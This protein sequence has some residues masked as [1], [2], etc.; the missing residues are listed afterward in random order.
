MERKMGNQDL[1]Y[2]LFR[3]E[4][5]LDTHGYKV[6]TK[7]RQGWMLE[8][9]KEKQSKFN[10][11]TKL[12]TFPVIYP[13]VFNFY[14]DKKHFLFNQE[15]SYFYLICCNGKTGDIFI[16]KRA[17]MIDQ[18]SHNLEHIDFYASKDY[19]KGS[20]SNSQLCEWSID[21]YSDLERC[22]FSFTDYREK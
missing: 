3:L 1:I 13:D 17:E 22:K 5:S 7:S 20:I 8:L 18:I 21:H 2:G 15:L 9:S 12:I 6:I 16:V 4:C 11:S 14:A 19:I 10:K